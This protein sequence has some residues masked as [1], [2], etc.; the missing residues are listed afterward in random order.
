MTTAR[1]QNDKVHR[2]KPVYEDLWGNWTVCGMQIRKLKD[3][4][5]EEA[6]VTCKSC[7]KFNA[8][9]ERRLT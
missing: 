4:K 3:W 9:Y 7:L 5:E 6:E 1:Y 8:A 2:I